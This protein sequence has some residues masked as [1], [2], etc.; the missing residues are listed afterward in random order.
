MDMCG[1]MGRQR[2]D[3]EDETCGPLLRT[4]SWE[5]LVLEL[6]NTGSNVCKL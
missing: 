2:K 5:A 3:E 4:E 6:D 1:L